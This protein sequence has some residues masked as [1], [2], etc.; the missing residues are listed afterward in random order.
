MENENLAKD[1]FHC[2]RCSKPDIFLIVADE[3]AGERQLREELSFNN[4]EFLDDLRKRGFHVLNNTSSNYNQ[5]MYS[6]ASMFKMNY[7]TNIEEKAS[8]KKDINECFR[9]TNKNAFVDY[10][11]NDGYTVENFSV[12]TFANQIFPG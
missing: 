11:L 12:F 3:Y 4:F 8:S 5:T 10:L 6:M 7:L 9:S 1:F 2:Q